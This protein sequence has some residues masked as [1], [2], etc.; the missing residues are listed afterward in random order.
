MSELN[1]KPTS[2]EL[3]Y[4]KASK[5]EMKMSFEANDFVLFQSDIHHTQHWHQCRYLIIWRNNFCCFVI[6]FPQTKTE[7]PYQCGNTTN[8]KA[9][10]ARKCNTDRMSQAS[11]KH[12]YTAGTEFKYRLGDRIS[13]HVFRG[14]S[15]PPPPIQKPVQY[16]KLSHG[17]FHPYPSQFIIH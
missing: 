9:Q 2:Y 1:I 6:S 5:R 12:S 10:G 4:D 15:S 8:S 3:R 16:L 17:R 7:R 11:D 13:Y 14:F